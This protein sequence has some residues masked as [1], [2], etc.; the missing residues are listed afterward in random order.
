MGRKQTITDDRLLAV[1]RAAFVELGPSASTREIAR[2][3]QVSEGVLFQRFGTKANLFFAAMVPPVLYLGSAPTK[4]VP[5]DEARLRLETLLLKLVD[6][7]RETVPV[8]GPLLSHQEFN[9]EEFARRHPASSLVLLRKELTQRLKEEQR[10]GVIRKGE[11]GPMALLLIS[12]GHTIAVF[13]RLGAHDAHFP[14]S[15]IRAA[16]D[17]LWVG[18]APV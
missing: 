6:Y 3:A 18:L 1:A 13:E 12:L 14:D 15:L 10:F 11:A 8:L 4:K 2:R 7:F 17:C 5:P 9:F 16:L